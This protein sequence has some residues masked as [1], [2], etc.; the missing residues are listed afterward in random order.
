MEKKMKIS[1]VIGIDPGANGGI[2]VWSVGHNVKALR[3]PKNITDLRD[4]L[5]YYAENYQPVVFL[6]KL[7]V[8][9]DDVFVQDN[10]AAMGKLYRIQKMMAN[11]E[12][13]RALIE[14]CGI[15]YVMVHPMTW[16]SK[17]KLRLHGE[18]EEKADRKRRY[19]DTAARFY[20]GVDVTLWNADA[21]LIMHFGRW[22][23]VNDTKWVKA[24]LPEREYQK[25]F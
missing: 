22:A 5:C 11:Y 10:R 18:K 1:A 7:S 19:K 9:A 4:F 13:L 12:H 3:M 8:R 6:E 24:N 17:L 15:P 14:T 23:L 16:Q 21:L 2:A 25:L 20:P